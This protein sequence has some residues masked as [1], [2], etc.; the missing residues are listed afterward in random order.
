MRGR[1]I[2]LEGAALVAVGILV[3]D[4]THRLETVDRRRF[5]ERSH[6]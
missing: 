6:A 4:S 1:R 2:G 5:E 3:E